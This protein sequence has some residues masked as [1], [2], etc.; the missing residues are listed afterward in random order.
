[1]FDLVGLDRPLSFHGHA[2]DDDGRGD[3]TR[4]ALRLRSL[5]SSLLDENAQLKRALASR[6]VIEQAKGILAERLGLDVNAAFA[7]LRDTARRR[8]ERL[9]SLATAVVEDSED[10]E[11]LFVRAERPRGSAGA[12]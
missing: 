8:R 4:E 7:L 11:S 5:V 2:V 12:S 1:M 9:H 3:G 10:V 6:I